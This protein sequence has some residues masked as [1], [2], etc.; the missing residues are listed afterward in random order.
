MEGSG[1]G[2]AEAKP[3][4]S[5]GVAHQWQEMDNK[6]SFQNTNS[7][8]HIERAPSSQAALLG[9]GMSLTRVM[10]QILLVTFLCPFKDN[11][12]LKITIGHVNDHDWILIKK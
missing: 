1:Q 8:K 5:D 11:L 3:M 7:D 10:L 2:D 12:V 6:S 9:R 4:K